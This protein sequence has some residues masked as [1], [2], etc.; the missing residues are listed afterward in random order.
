MPAT[1]WLADSGSPLGDAVPCE[2]TCQAVSGGYTAGDVANWPHPTAG[3]WIR[4]EQRTN[5]TQHAISTATNLLAGANHALPHAPVPCG[6]IDHYDTRIQL[7]GWCPP[8]APV[9][10]VD[11]DLRSRRFVALHHAD[12]RVAS[13]FGWNSPRACS[14]IA[15]APRPH[16]RLTPASEGVHMIDRPI[17]RPRAWP[18]VADRRPPQPS[19]P[20]ASAC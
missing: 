2:P 12:G 8:D 16:G 9:E 18:R 17:G 5:A 15:P 1:D 14:G 4:L 10:V 7:H 6:W 19:R 20:R 13:T 3:G 11:G